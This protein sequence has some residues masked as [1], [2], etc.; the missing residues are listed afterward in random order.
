MSAS[1]KNS[2]PGRAA[3]R[4]A[5]RDAFAADAGWS[6]AAVE[7]FPG[8]ASARAYF[9]LRKEGGETA[10]LMDAP[11]AAEAP[12]APGD[13]DEAERARLGYN[14]LARLAGNNVAAFAGLAQAL[15][16]RG[17]SA[18]KILAGDADRG[19]LL[20]EDLG[21]GVFARLVPEHAHEGALYAAA[22]DALAALYR[23]SLPDEVSYQGADWRIHPLDPAAQRAEARLF[24]DWYAT[25]QG[26]LAPDEAA[27]GQ[28]DALWTDIA[29]AFEAHTP[30][31]ALRDYHAE[32]LIW[33][34]EREHHARVGL[35][36]FQDAVFAHPAY[37]LVS[38]L[39]DARRDVDPELAPALKDRFFERAGLSD[40]DAFEAAYALAGAQRNAKILGIFVRLARRDNKP[41]YLAMIPRV[42]RHFVRDLSHPAAAEIRRWCE[43]CAPFVFEEARK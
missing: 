33:L 20:I 14:A 13:A 22:V 29:P 19:L 26:G 36:D 2:D 25:H 23:S 41:R 16:A 8:D 24:V 37:D 35:L 18:P 40:R 34:P 38:L 31:L 32:N 12:H 9:R 11:S 28:F 30:G 7:P 10:I 5:E 3:V 1:P 27:A 43:D 42:A 15:T 17:F 21:E 39:E 6:D 4:A